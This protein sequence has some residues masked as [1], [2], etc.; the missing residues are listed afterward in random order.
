M[1]DYVIPKDE[2]K[3]LDMVGG[4]WDKV[5]TKFYAIC[6]KLRDSRLLE[7]TLGGGRFQVWVWCES[8]T[9]INK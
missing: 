1:C 7:D 8:P 3:E 9:K 6:S 4:V 2:L 5:P